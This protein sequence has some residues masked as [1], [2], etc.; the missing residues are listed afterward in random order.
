MS[1]TH[2]SF[3]EARV[4]HPG[5][6]KLELEYNLPVNKAYSQVKW[7]FSEIECTRTRER[8]N[9][10]DGDRGIR[11][12]RHGY[13]VLLPS[14]RITACIQFTDVEGSAVTRLVRPIYSERG[15]SLVVVGGE[16]DGWFL[17]RRVEHT[18]VKGLVGWLVGEPFGPVKQCITVVSP[19][20]WLAPIVSVCL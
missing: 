7:R 4:I 5:R 15:V 19:S 11:L 9:G 13:V 16:R 8:D 20:T 14:D 17:G 18:L 3:E 1:V 6:H 10:Y 12:L 2:Q